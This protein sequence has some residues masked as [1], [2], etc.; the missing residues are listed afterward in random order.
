[1]KFFYIR[2]Y[3]ILAIALVFLLTSCNPK[4]SEC[5]NIIQ[6]HNQIVIDSRDLYKNS[7][8]KDLD[9]MRKSATNFDNAAKSMGELSV[10]DEQLKVF[11]DKLTLMYQSSSQETKKVIKAIEDKN[12]QNFRDGLTKLSSVASP[13]QDI[14]NGINA[15]CQQKE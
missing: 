7:A 5:K 4:V 13:E 1:M 10:S 6:I 11:K 12:T 2:T 9:L 15:Y 8:K 3:S 14:V